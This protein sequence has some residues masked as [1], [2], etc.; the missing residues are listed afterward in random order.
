M[1]NSY[2]QCVRV[3]VL[4][5]LLGVMSGVFANPA[6]RLQAAS[7]SGQLTTGN[8]KWNRM[9]T[10]NVLSGQQVFYEAL[11]IKIQTGGQYNIAINSSGFAGALNTYA[12]A[13]NSAQP[14]VNF[15][16]NGVVAGSP[17]AFGQ[18][19]FFAPGDY[20]LVISTNQAGETGLFNGSISGPDSVTIKPPPPLAILSNPFD[21]TITP[22]QSATLRVSTIGRTPKT[23]QWFQ[24]NS[25]NTA[26]PITKGRNKG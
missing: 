23:F 13:F 16:D 21:T 22:G 3:A 14:Q 19:V 25:G 20:D 11:S 26:N 4:C 10:I 17:G 8:D 12:I 15:W 2:C 18:T 24:G 5:A 1:S 7:F 9:T 6:P